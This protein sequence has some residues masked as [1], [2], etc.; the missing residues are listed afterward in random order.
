MRVMQG[1]QVSGCSQS[2]YPVMDSEETI[3][4]RILQARDTVF[5]EELFYEMFR[6]AR[7]IAGLGVT[8]RQNLIQIPA[9]DDLEILL[10]LVDVDENNLQFDHGISQQG[11]SLAQ[12]LGHT[13]RI[14]LAYAHRQSL[15]RRTQLPLPLV[16]K[17]RPVPE[18]H[19]LRPAL[20]YIQHMFHV[21]SVQSMLDDL[22]GVLK[23][24]GLNPQAY[25]SKV[26]SPGQGQQSQPPTVEGLVE[27]FLK[28]LKSTFE[29]ELLTP[30]GSFT[31]S[32]CTN[33]SSSPYGTSFN[34]TLEMPKYP[35][36]KSPGRLSQQEE[37]EAAIT[38][39]LLLDVVFAIASN[40]APQTDTEKKDK[41]VWQAVFPQHGELL[42]SSDSL[43]R[44][45][46][47]ITFSRQ[48]MFVETYTVR[49]FDGTG[50]GKGENAAL[51]SKSDIWKP[52]TTAR[53]LMD[54][55]RAIPTHGESEPGR[56]P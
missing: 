27:S 12:G 7:A 30:R 33:L 6:E 40:E 22:F 5:E 39:L 36:L 24:A 2:A 9:S 1:G 26:F 55:V 10:D 44:K 3:E 18:H 21:Q 17:K 35:D 38:H 49:C 20:A 4:S 42:L 31:I 37:V 16:P 46:M 47:K 34:L 53:P 50:R 48:E 43:K 19:L 45:K 41:H 29:G 13:I 51:D 54:Y 11:S 14:L 52:L 25:T 56:N 23:S 32:I 28:P 15:E 8:T